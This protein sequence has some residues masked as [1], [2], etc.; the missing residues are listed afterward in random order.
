MAFGA[1]SF[2][3]F[4][5]R[6]PLPQWVCEEIEKEPD[7]AYSDRFGRRNQE[8]ISLG[9]D[10]LPVLRGRS[11]IQAYSDFMRNFRDTFRE[12]LGDIITVSCYYF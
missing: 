3:L 9:C 8:Y 10:V 12:F 7:L 4:L 1:E 5:V 2:D 11:P 6:I